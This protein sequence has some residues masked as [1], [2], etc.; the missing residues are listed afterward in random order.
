MAEEDFDPGVQMARAMREGFQQVNK[1][2]RLQQL[3]SEVREYDRMSPSK[4]RTWR[5]ETERFAI[6]LPADNADYDIYVGK[7]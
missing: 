1:N 5:E 7:L 6:S 3:A 4:Y 2:L